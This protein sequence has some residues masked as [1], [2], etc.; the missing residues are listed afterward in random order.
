LAA[1]T[2]SPG[3]SVLFAAAGVGMNIA[4]TINREKRKAITTNAEALEEPQSF[5]SI[6]TSPSSGMFDHSLFGEG[7][8]FQAISA[9]INSLMGVSAGLWLQTANQ[10]FLTQPAMW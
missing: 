5:I 2:N 8:L 3:W 10:V 4:P 9:V 7:I 6:L 1:L